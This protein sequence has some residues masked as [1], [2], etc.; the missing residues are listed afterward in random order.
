MRSL[1]DGVDHLFV[2]MADG[3]AAF[4]VL[5]EDLRLP[6]LW[7]FTS[8]GTFSSGGVSVGSVKLEII[9]SNDVTPF[10]I[11]QDAPQI[12]GIAFRPAS[13][14]DDA[15]LAEVDA[16][17]IQRSEPE[18]FERDGK[19]GWTNLYFLDFVSTVA[20]AFVCEYH[21]PEPGDLETRRRA[22]RGAGG[23]RLG[24]LDAV[25]LVIVTRDTHAARERWRRL[26]DPLQ[27][28]PPLTWRPPV[29]PAITLLAGDDERVDH[30]SLAVRSQAAARRVWDEVADG[31]LGRFPLRFV[32]GPP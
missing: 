29:G 17:S 12:Q 16:R 1:V 19:P 7:P 14:I 10:S 25:E 26:F 3:P 20:G 30:L 31:A 21:T 28:V 6:V 23:S 2:P 18:L 13:P 22:L 4:A 5:T 8:F 9:E 24:I 15:Y 11:A 32:A 27:P